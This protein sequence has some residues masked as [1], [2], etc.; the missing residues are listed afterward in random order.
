MASKREIAIQGL[1]PQAVAL[2]DRWAAAASIEAEDDTWTVVGAAVR[3][4]LAVERQQRQEA[5][6]V[7]DEAANTIKMLMILQTALM[8]GG[9]VAII[10]LAFLL[11]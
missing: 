3:A 9:A 2:L 7:V 4:T 5:R 10:I 11:R 8:I 1:P 6:S